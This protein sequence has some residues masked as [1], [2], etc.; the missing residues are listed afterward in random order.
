MFI[1]DCSELDQICYNWKPI[2]VVFKYLI[3]ILQW[4]VPLILLALGSYDMF[5]AMTRAD[6][7]DAVADARKSLIM[8]IIYG[9]VIFIVPFLVRLVLKLVEDN[10]LNEYDYTSPTSW[11]SCWNNVMDKD[12]SD[13]DDIY[14]KKNSD[15]ITDSENDDN[16]GTTGKKTCYV[17]SDYSCPNGGTVAPKDNI[18]S[19]PTCRYTI[20]LKENSYGI[21]INDEYPIS[22]DKKEFNT[23]HYHT[24]DFYITCQTVYGYDNLNNI[25]PDPTDDFSFVCVYEAIAGNERGHTTKPSFEIPYETYVCNPTFNCETEWSLCTKQN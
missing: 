21:G 3:S 14:K 25:Y 22:K 12:Y 23:D 16:E 6:K 24:I 7:D 2:L 1:L 9:L 17:Y 8:R 19:K 10:T 15:S 20:N 11:I 13:C 5:K 4:S 18:T